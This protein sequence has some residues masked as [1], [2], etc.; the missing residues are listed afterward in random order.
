MILEKIFGKRK[1]SNVKIEVETLELKGKKKTDLPEP[2]QWSTDKI[3]KFQKDH[4]LTTDGIIGERTIRSITESDLKS[5]LEEYAKYSDHGTIMIDTHEF[6]KRD[7]L[8]P[9]GRSGSTGYT[10]YVYTGGNSS[11][12]LKSISD[13]GYDWNELY[14]V[15]NIGNYGTSGSPMNTGSMGTSGLSKSSRTAK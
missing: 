7:F 6:L 14:S 4:G 1:S 9:I 11:A 15:Q 12:D 5:P 10:I 13:S 8:K 3:K 2:S